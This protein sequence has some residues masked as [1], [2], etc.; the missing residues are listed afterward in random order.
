[1]SQPGVTEFSERFHFDVKVQKVSSKPRRLKIV[2][3]DSFLV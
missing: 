2:A 1:M 3:E